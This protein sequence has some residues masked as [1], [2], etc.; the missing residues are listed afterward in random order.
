MKKIN[1]PAVLFLLF[2]G[3]VLLSGCQRAYYGTMEA[4]GHPKRELL[5]DRVASAR[6]SQTEAKEQFE[7]ALEQFSS[8][9]NF[10]GGELEEKY[11]QL[12]AEFERSE[13]KAKK[14][15][16][17]IGDVENVAEALFDEWTSEL[18][19]YS[20]DKL[21][22]ASERKLEQTRKRYTQ[23]INAM[24]RAEE[25]TGPV[26]SAFRDQVLFLKHNLNARAIASLHDELA[27]VEAEIG[28][29]IKEMEVSI[30][31]ADKFI[32]AMAAE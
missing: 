23:L 5:V 11:K 20:S 26:L 21:R 25:K 31:E 29:L 13:T 15:K 10:S 14:V 4:L 3:S 16:K 19:D 18:E 8:V 32:S 22:R 2:G 1:L 24:H 28:S 7:S 12:N 17:R 30:A 6:D 27:N 9:L